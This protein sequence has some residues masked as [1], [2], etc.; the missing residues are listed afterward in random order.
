MPASIRII[1]GRILSEPAL[2]VFLLAWLGYYFFLL[3]IP[4]TSSFSNLWLAIVYQLIFVALAATPLILGGYFFPTTEPRVDKYVAQDQSLVSLT[5]ILGLL[6][7]VLAVVSLFIDKAFYMGIDYSQGVCVAREEMRRLGVERPGISSV[8]SFFGNMFGHCYFVSLALVMTQRVS[9]KLFYPTVGISFL[10]LMA[11]ATVAASRS[12]F[13]L[14]GTFIL[15]FICIRLLL[16][17]PLP[18]INK[19]NWIDIVVGLAMIAAAIWFVLMI[20]VCRATASN[21][22]GEAYLDSFAPF[23]GATLTGDSPNETASPIMLSI[24]YTTHSA[25][26]FAGILTLPP[27]EGYAMFSSV[28]FLL[29]KVG[30]DP[31]WSREWVLAGRFASLPGTLYHDFTFVG[32]VIGALALGTFSA[33]CR[34]VL[35]RYKPS[36]LIIGVVSAVYVILF[37]SPLT[38]AADFMA[39]PFIC[40]GFV[41]VPMLSL[42]VRNLHAQRWRNA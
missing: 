12:T 23:L 13:I 18:R 34:L 25:Y 3:I 6:L 28:A 35:A 15:A 39:F 17:V 32:L 26:T 29:E 37:L 33:G 4:Y 7:S 16:R 41:F 14:L 5:I 10:C 21:L 1:A 30:L 36:A 22:T 31:G 40:F 20:F 8:F 9:R 42:L 27:T 19:I 24:L 11:L 38:F 2:I